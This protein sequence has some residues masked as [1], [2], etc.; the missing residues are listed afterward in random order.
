MK[1]TTFFIGVGGLALLLIGSVIS[2]QKRVI[3]NRTDSAPTGIYWVQNMQPGK[4]D[5]VIVSV[6]SEAATWAQT[7]G[8]VGEDWPLLKRVLG[9]AGDRICRLSGQ[10]YINQKHEATAQARTSQGLKL[11][12]WTG[13]RTLLEHELFLLNPHPKSL[14]GR[15]FGPTKIDDVDGVAVLLFSI[16]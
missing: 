2:P 11:P 15:Y 5:L 6:G 10:I 13:C 4:G 8:A 3:W 7:H 1:K 12:E 14:D 9:Q 16:N